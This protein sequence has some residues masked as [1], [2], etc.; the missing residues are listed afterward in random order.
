MK[1]QIEKILKRSDGSRVKVEVSLM[2]QSSYMPGIQVAF[3]LMVT[4]C[5]PRKRTWSRS[6]DLSL[7]SDEEALNAKLELWQSIKPF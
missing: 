6:N 1:S 2:V 5:A 7:L 4:H 3:R